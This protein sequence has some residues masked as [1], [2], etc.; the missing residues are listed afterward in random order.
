[1]LAS[2]P[3]VTVDL[4]VF[5]PL[6]RG[7]KPMP[8]PL[9]V[10]HAPAQM[11]SVNEQQQPQLS[12]EMDSLKLAAAEIALCYVHALDCCLLLAMLYDNCGQY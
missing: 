12:Y 8:P 6:N 5:V 2:P 4:D 7:Y 10:G 3:I 11:L 1:M 9:Y